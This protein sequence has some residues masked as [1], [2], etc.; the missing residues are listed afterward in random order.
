VP[1]EQ[2][3]PGAGEPGVVTTALFAPQ[4]GDQRVRKQAQVLPAARAVARRDAQR[5]AQLRGRPV[6]ELRPVQALDEGRD[7]GPQ[8]LARGAQLVGGRQRQRDAQPL[9]GPGVELLRDD[10]VATLERDQRDDPAPRERIEDDELLA[11]LRFRRAQKRVVD[12]ARAPRPP[13][14]DGHRRQVDLA[15]ACF[16][17]RSARHRRRV[18]AGDERAHGAAMTSAPSVGQR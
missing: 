8:P 16:G 10:V 14:I 15:V 11:E 9:D 7:R 5:V 2:V 12:G 6:V 1:H 18:E 13:A 4:Q 3:P 17:A